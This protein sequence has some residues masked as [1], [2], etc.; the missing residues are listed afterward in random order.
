MSKII[1]NAI[2]YYDSKDENID[3]IL[4]KQ[5]SFEI[6]ESSNDYDFPIII[7]Y[8]KDRN[9][10]LKSEFQFIAEYYHY[11]NVWVWAWS[12]P[13]LHKSEIT[14]SRNILNY[15]I[16]VTQDDILS[17]PLNK[18]LKTIFTNSRLKISDKN[19]MLILKALSLYLSK[20]NGILVLKGLKGVQV[21][22]GKFSKEAILILTK[23]IK[24]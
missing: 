5:N 24:T 2:K 3:S 9:I 17:D 10:I 23:E 21:S 12:V 22:K 13:D 6:I 19:D 20:K 18:F 4:K 16:N 14:L 7:I 15:G 1:Q 11:Y 8:D